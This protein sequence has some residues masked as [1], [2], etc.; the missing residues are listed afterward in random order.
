MNHGW[1][2]KMNE[3]LSESCVELM[4]CCNCINYNGEICLESTTTNSDRDEDFHQKV[5]ADN[6]C[7]NGLFTQ[8]EN[9]LPSEFITLFDDIVK[10]LK[11]YIDLKEEYYPILTTWII[12]TYLHNKFYS[13]PYLFFNAMHGSGKS[14][15]L[16]LLSYLCN[17]GEKIAS[18]NEAV[19][20]RSEPN[21]TFCIDE[22]ERINHKDYQALRELLNAAYKKGT[23]VKR[24]KESRQLNP[25]T[26]KLEKTFIVEEFEPFRPIAIANISG[27]EEVL[28]DRCITF[29][30]EKSDN[31]NITS[32]LEIFDLDE[33]I[34]SIKVRLI[35]LVYDEHTLIRSVGYAQKHIQLLQDWNK[36]HTYTYTTT[37]PTQNNINIHLINKIRE[38]KIKGRNLEL[39]FPLFIVAEMF[40]KEEQIIN[41]MKKITQ[42]KTEDEVYE[43]KDIKVIDFVSRKE[44]YIDNWIG[45]NQIISEFRIFR[46]EQIIDYT[47]EWLSNEWMGRALKRLALIKG[48]RRLG[49]GVEMILDIEKAKYKM[50]MFK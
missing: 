33:E 22:L 19:L 9:V 50:K 44:E 36:L 43:S 35:K 8:K 10:V 11:K 45:L 2:A 29:I 47:K 25:E 21:A 37:L 34:K 15:L 42:E 23:K 5:K 31:E 30:L 49:T 6:R 27:M 28:S 26:M 1:R 39:C 13:Y 20:F 41:T 14:R 7:F 4:R 17:K 16:L 18:L 3:I 38:S 32:M 40:G 46:D 24:M 12:G 48:K